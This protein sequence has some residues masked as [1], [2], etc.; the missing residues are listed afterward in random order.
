MGP[1]LMGIYAVT[2]A[3]LATFSIQEQLLRRKVK[4]FTGGLVFKAHRLLHHSTIG[5][6]VT[7]KKK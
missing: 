1:S 2:F 5:L 3:G 7:K 6:R 4:R